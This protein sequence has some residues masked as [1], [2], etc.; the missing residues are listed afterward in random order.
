MRGIA[1]LF[2]AVIDLVV[3]V[4]PASADVQPPIGPGPEIRLSLSGSAPHSAAV[5]ARQP[6][7]VVAWAANEGGRGSDVYVAYSR[8]NGDS[9]RAPM[10]LTDKGTQALHGQPDLQVVF[11]AATSTATSVSSVVIGWRI[12]K[13]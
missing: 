11:P 8:D 9:F 2:V 5:A 7:V 13:E 1:L 4:R 10:R 3:V 6:I 12:G